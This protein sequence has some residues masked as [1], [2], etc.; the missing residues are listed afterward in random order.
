M[1]RSLP[2]KVVFMGSPRFSSVILEGLI[3]SGIVPK[4]V[5][6][7]EDKT[8]ERGHKTI[9]TEVKKI[10]KIYSI[11][12]FQPKKLKDDETIEALKKLSPHF[13]VVAA[14]GKILPKSLLEIPKIAAV[15]VHASLLPRWRGASPIQYAILNGDKKTGITIMKMD[16]GVDTGDIYQFSEEIEIEEKETTLTL[17]EKLATIG[18]EL[19]PKSLEKI[20]SGEISLIKQDESKAT[21]APRIKKEDGFIDFSKN[22]EH[23]E[24]MVRAFTP[25]PKCF[26]YLKGK[27]VAVLDS[28]I[29]Q[30]IES[31]KTGVLL[32]SRELL[33]SCGDGTSIK[34]RQVQMEGKKIVKGED[35]MRGVRIEKGEEIQ[36][37][38]EKQ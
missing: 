17:T 30:K 26:F 13:V 9:E 1:G 14:Y 34:F 22:A 6:T 11:P 8:G 16:E 33:F 29:G 20:Y 37:F 2:V 31:E 4:A 12:V 15:N 35:F 7:Q 36:G 28:E 10:A 5:F 32:S 3:K 38:S 27:R 21:Y 23:I 19:L 25:W 18:A 24:R